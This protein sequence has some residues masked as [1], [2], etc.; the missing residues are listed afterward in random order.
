MT[1]WQQHDLIVVGGGAAGMACAITAAE[2]GPRVVVVEKTDDVGGTLH[3]SAG[4]LSG[5]GTRRQ[6]TR[7]I[8]DTPDHHF[9]EVMAL[10]HG[11]ADPVLTRLAVDEAPRTIDWLE[12]LGFEFAAESP[13][14]YY[15]HEPYSRPRTHW[16]T[17]GGRSVLRALGGRWT[18]LV[19]SGQITV[20]FRHRAD[21]LIRDHGTVVGVRAF[22]PDG[23]VDLHAPST[24]LTTGGYGANHEF[25]AAHTP[26]APRLISACRRSSTADGI[27]MAMEAGAV[28]RGGE[29]HLPTVGGF[30]P[31]PGSGYAGEPP[32]FAILNPATWPA[33]AIHVNRRGERFLAE[34]LFGPD[35]R[36]RA[37][38]EQPGSE[39]WVV[40]DDASLADGRSFHPLLSADQVRQIADYEIYAWTGRNVAALAA[41]AGVDGDGLARTIDEWNRAVASR[42]DPL[43][44]REPGPPITTPPFYAFL[45]SPVVVI[46]F[47]GIA[48]DGE[49]RVLDGDGDPV[50][51]L[52]AA[53]EVLGASATGGDA[54]CGGM[55][56]TPALSFG[57]ILGRRLAAAT[58]TTTAMLSAG[59]VD[60][61]R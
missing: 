13:A 4:Q 59:K 21:E 38:V 11:H 19:D 29:H 7:G 40:F 54:F 27:V 5:A 25:F 2:L 39:V 37:I 47:G 61:A 30:E 48:A 58:R 57:R 41:K 50:P 35:R 8:E 15:G 52:Y 18:E 33:R 28:F 14:L 31:E 17:E 43:G 22:G 46:T 56:A 45:V 60:N 36:E 34:D 53:G 1:D 12:D 44:V 42:H 49:L 20:L 3:L 32:Q 26:Q 55:A 10:S 24:V 23:P 6:R 16:G 51:G 9:A